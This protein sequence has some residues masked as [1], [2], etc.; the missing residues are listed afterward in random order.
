MT[1]R[2]ALAGTGRD[3]RRA[4]R[5]LAYERSREGEGERSECECVYMLLWQPLVTV[6][7]LKCASLFFFSSFS[8]CSRS[9]PVVGGFVVH[10]RR[11]PHH[12]MPL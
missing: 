3:T 12:N 4:L 6:F 8:A 11:K 9:Q 5:G 2:R 1:T 10:L 7:L